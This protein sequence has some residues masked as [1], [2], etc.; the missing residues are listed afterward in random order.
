[1]LQRLELNF[2]SKIISRSLTGIISKLG[3]LMLSLLFITEISKDERHL[4]RMSSYI[5]D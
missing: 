5:S 2:Q 4:D 3:Q 1:M